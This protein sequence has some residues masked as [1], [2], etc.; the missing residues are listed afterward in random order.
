MKSVFSRI[1]SKTTMVSC[2]E[3]PKIVRIAATVADVTRRLLAE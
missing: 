2:T 1:R 3:Y